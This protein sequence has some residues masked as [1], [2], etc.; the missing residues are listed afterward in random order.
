MFRIILFLGLIFPAF[1]FGQTN[2]VHNSSF[3]QNTIILPYP[4]NSQ[5]YAFFYLGA[6]FKI[7]S[8]SSK[9]S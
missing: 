5:M 4:N 8:Y 3:E 2:L 7:F 9:N 1:A 6:T